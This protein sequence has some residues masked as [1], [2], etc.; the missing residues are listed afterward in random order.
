MCGRVH[1]A[2]VL[3]DMS[4]PRPV[5]ARLVGRLPH[6]LDGLPLSVPAC[7]AADLTTDRRREVHSIITRLKF[8]RRIPEQASFRCEGIIAC[9]PRLLD[10]LAARM[11]GRHRY[12]SP[13]SPPTP[14]HPL[15][16]CTADSTEM[17]KNTMR[18]VMFG[19]AS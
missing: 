13:P 8:G 19:V 2:T 7:R 10:L 3:P 12:A 5:A 18:P 11:K 9:L 14:P 4:D 17:K 6:R 1:S 16:G 15:V